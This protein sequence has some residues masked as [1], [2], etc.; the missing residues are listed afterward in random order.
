[1]PPPLGTKISH[2]VPIPMTPVR[3]TFLYAILAAMLPLFAWW[4]SL[5]GVPD[6]SLFG[7]FGLPAEA[8]AAPLWVTA[9]FP[10]ACAITAGFFARNV[11]KTNLLLLFLIIGTAEL[12]G[13]SWVMALNGIAF[14][15]LPSAAA[16][17]LSPLLVLIHNT[18]GPGRRRRDL[19]MALSGRL[20]PAA[21]AD[22]HRL[23]GIP[24]IEKEP[25]EAV[26]V[27]CRVM[28][29]S[30]LSST[31]GPEDLKTAARIVIGR[32]VAKARQE[33]AF[34]DWT[35]TGGFN[36][37]F[38]LAPSKVPLANQTLAFLLELLTEVREWNSECAKLNGQK[39]DLRFGAESG[40]M[41]FMRDHD[42]ER[43]RLR[44]VGEV[45][46]VAERIV[47]LNSVYGSIVAIGPTLYQSGATEVQVR[48]LDFTPLGPDR[49]PSEIYELISSATG[50]DEEQ[51]SRRD[52]YWR[53]VIFCREG[54]FDEAIAEF[55]QAAV[56]GTHD[57]PLSF[58]LNRA[59]R[60]GGR[61]SG[62]STAE[63]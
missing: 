54:R 56:P 26:V 50:L 24:A 47:N 63:E 23:G 4:Q 39:L 61:S 6:A 29:L 36:A 37:I 17:F 48:P 28:N 46:L 30:Q 20:T 8:P 55:E 13:F 12:F 33:G 18:S 57:G 45:A 21:E 15:F 62:A 7:L 38:G 41:L 14:S 5:F 32:S 59:I 27:C 25:I 42:D 43:G 52:S 49:P 10:F 11:P 44:A 34:V 3:T 16:L 53:G 19:A 1:M 60:S 22:L 9:I 40:A 31:L 2:E 58:Y 51:T 35:G